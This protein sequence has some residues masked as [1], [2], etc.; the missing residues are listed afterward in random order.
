MGRYQR[1]TAPKRALWKHR[2]RTRPDQKKKKKKRKASLH[3]LI[4]HLPTHR[5]V[6]ISPLISS[7]RLRGGITGRNRCDHRTVN[8][9][10]VNISACYPRLG[11]KGEES[12]CAFYSQSDTCSGEGWLSVSG[13]RRMGAK[14]RGMGEDD[15]GE[16]S[17]L[18]NSCPRVSL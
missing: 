11:R 12:T 9:R 1:K 15:E 6:K 5:P 18:C 10:P 4:C 8:C 2:G 16:E 14:R 17:S 13:A 7:A 3:V